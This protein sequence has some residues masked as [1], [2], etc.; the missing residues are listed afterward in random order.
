MSRLVFLKKA[1]ETPHIICIHLIHC[2]PIVPYVVLSGIACL[3]RKQL[4]GAR[5]AGAVPVSCLGL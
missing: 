1:F 4:F 2:I 3:D 5:Q